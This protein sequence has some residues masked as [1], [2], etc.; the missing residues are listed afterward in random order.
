ML[1]FAYVVFAQL[2]NLQMSQVLEAIHLYD[3]NEIFLQIQVACV[4]GDPIGNIP[5]TSA[6]A[7][8]FAELVA[9][10]AY[11]GTRLSTNQTCHHQQLEGQE[12]HEQGVG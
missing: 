12:Q 5:Q 6:G 11:R 4:G 8:D 7:D 10:G 9:A 3:L 1:N 2:Q